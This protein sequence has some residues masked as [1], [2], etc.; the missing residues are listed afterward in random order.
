MG[1]SAVPESIA[2]PPAG[3]PLQARPVPHSLAQ[4]LLSLLGPLAES[5]LYTRSKARF[6]PP[7]HR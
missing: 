7:T 2:L 3:R 5:S 1:G 6:L 4:G